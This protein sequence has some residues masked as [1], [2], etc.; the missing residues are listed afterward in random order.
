MVFCGKCGLQLTSGNRVCP[1]C[2]TPT[3]TDLILEDSQPNSPTIASDSIFGS[4]QPQPGTQRT[5]NQGTPVQPEPLTL[6]PSGSNYGAAEQMANEPTSMMGTQAP[7]MAGQ[8]P[9]RTS[10]PGYVPQSAGNYSQQRASYPGFATQGDAYYQ[11]MSGQYG[12]SSTDAARV[13]ARGRI[14]GL[15][16]ILVGL[17]LVLG[18]MLL[19]FLTHN[20][21]T[22]ASSP[23]QHGQATYALLCTIAC[24]GSYPIEHD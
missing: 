21:T 3:E 11:A 16:L 23:V 2:G 19:F 4:N 24:F 20:A 8:T 15:L 9:I 22:S 18:A 7:G 5:V 12:T 17:L 13:Q 1:R 10:Y 6:G 14:V